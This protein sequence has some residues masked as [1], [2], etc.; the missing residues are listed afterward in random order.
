M[1]VAIRTSLL[2]TIPH[3][4]VIDRHHV[5]APARPAVTRGRICGQGVARTAELAAQHATCIADE[6]TRLILHRYAALSLK[7]GTSYGES[8]CTFGDNCWRNDMGLQS[9]GACA[10]IAPSPS[11]RI[12]A[13]ID[14]RNAVW[15][16]VVC[17]LP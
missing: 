14:V 9:S 13:Y 7:I 11:D 17:S 5:H 4:F 10:T 8:I 15:F 1:D 2:C 12:L 3:P 6:H 16:G